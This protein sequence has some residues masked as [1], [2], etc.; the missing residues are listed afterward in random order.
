MTNIKS[1]ILGFILIFCIF[2]TLNYL[3]SKFFLKNEFVLT[4]EILK[5]LFFASIIILFRKYIQRK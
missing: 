2:L 3:F 1:N 5:S 4:V